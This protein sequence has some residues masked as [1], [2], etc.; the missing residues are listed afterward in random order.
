MKNIIS[1]TILLFTLS[2]FSQ[3]I[4]VKDVKHN[5]QSGQKF[6]LSGNI[7]SDDK[8]DITKVFQKKAKNEKGTSIE[9]KGELFI[10]NAIISEV[11]A[12]KTD[13]FLAIDKHKNGTANLMVC[14]E[15]NNEYLIPKSKEYKKAVH[16]MENLSREISLVV[17]EKEF[18]KEEKSFEKFKE[19]ITS[20]EKKTWV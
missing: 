18:E 17:L 10:D 14:F 12:N 8:K 16:F 11:S 5:F 9:K 1:L 13:V 19:K 7:H 3:K 15:V 20:L 2:A 4:V 6:A